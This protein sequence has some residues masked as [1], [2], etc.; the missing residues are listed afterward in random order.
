VRGTTQSR[1]NNSLDASG[2]SGLVIDNS[3]VTWLS[4][5]A[6]TQPLGCSWYRT[7]SGSDRVKHS[8]SSLHG[9]HSHQCSEDF[10]V[11][12]HS[13]HA[14]SGWTPSLPLRVP[15]RTLCS[16][17]RNPT[18]RWTRAAGAYFSTGLVRRRCF[19]SRRRVNS[20]VG[21]LVVQNRER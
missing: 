4:P 11:R 18:N 5:A 3:S 17:W 21:L 10:N 19:D 15:Y 13:T 6:S 16:A 12:T 20:T 14:V 8:T 1:P 9:N 7:G 2:T